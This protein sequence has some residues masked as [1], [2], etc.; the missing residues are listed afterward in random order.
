MNITFELLLPSTRNVKSWASS[1]R[2]D[3]AGSLGTGEVLG[4]QWALAPTDRAKHSFFGLVEAVLT[5]NGPAHVYAAGLHIS[6]H[7]SVHGPHRASVGTY[8]PVTCIHSA[9]W[10]VECAATKLLLGGLAC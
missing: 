3:Q 8:A 5:N 10:C 2:D 7:M 9:G 4:G 6:L 1:R